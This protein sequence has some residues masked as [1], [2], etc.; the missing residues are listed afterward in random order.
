[1]VAPQAQPREPALMPAGEVVK[2]VGGLGA[3]VYH[4][5]KVEDRRA[6]LIRLRRLVNFKLQVARQIQAAVHVAHGVDGLVG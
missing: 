5:P 6:P 2:H 4:I 3:A 1:M